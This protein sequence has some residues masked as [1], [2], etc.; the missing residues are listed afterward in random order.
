MNTVNH[1]WTEERCHHLVVKLEDLAGVGRRNSP[2]G[3]RED[4][5]LDAD[6]V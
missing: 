5:V 1:K 3:D 6:A 4:I 2:T